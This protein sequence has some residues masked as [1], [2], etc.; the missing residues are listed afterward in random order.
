MIV[1]EAEETRTAVAANL[2]ERITSAGGK[3]A[4]VILNMRSF[5]I[6]RFI[7]SRI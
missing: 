6:P 5:H 7:Y 4:G 1:V 3:V 2:I